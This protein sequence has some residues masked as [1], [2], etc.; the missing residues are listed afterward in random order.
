MK[1]T[2]KKPRG[3]TYANAVEQTLRVYAALDRR[4]QYIGSVQSEMEKVAKHTRAHLVAANASASDAEINA[5]LE[6]TMVA[7]GVR[8]TETKP[9]PRGIPQD[10]QAAR[11]AERRREVRS[12]AKYRR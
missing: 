9:Q 10:V 7:G 5:V 12:R 2:Y 4:E 1:K 11:R 8:T 6:R 3:F